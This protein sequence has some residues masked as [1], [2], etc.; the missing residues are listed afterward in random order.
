M[1]AARTVEHALV[2]AVVPGSIIASVSPASDQA[3]AGEAGEGWPARARRSR[4]R[5]A[6]RSACAAAPPTSATVH[7]ACRSA[8]GPCAASVLPARTISGSAS[9][10]VTVD[11]PGPGLDRGPGGDA[12][13]GPEVEDRGRRPARPRDPDLAEDL[14][15]R[16]EGCRCAGREVGGDLALRARRTAGRSA[17]C[18]VGVGERAGGA[19]ELT[20]VA[21]ADDLVDACLQRVRKRHSRIVAWPGGSRASRR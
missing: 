9:T 12:R 5:R 1:T 17:A 3:C 21:G 16:R 8:G 19:L 18:A 7:R 2:P 11:D 10:S 20:A 14:G 4:R 15:R 6:T 13:P